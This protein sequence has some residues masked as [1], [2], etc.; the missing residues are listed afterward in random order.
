MTRPLVLTDRDKAALA[1]LQ[2]QLGSPEMFTRWL[3]VQGDQ[4]RQ[5]WPKDMARAESKAEAKASQSAL[6]PNPKQY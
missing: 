1:F 3:E 4:F 5:R 6:F 2:E